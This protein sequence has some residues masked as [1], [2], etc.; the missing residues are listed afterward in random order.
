MYC[1]NVDISVNDEQV[2]FVLHET[3]EQ[4]NSALWSM[5]AGK[6]TASMFYGACHTRI[7]K[8]APSLLRTICTP[9]D[10]CFKYAATSWGI[11]NESKVRLEYATMQDAQHEHFSCQDCGLF[12]S[13]A[14][15]CLV[16]LQMA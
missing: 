15:L 9:Q 8:P 10:Q 14:I 11:A 2:K 1:D 4:S 7:E 3:K 6:V 12:F 16:L 13:T 5:R